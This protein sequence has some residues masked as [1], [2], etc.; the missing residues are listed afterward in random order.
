HGGEADA[1]AE[2]HDVLPL[3][4]DAEAFAERPDHVEHV[5]GLERGE[6]LGAAAD[7]L[8][9]ELEPAA[10]TRHAIDALRAAEPHLDR[11]RRRAQQLEELPWCG[12]ERSEEHTSELQSRVDLVCRLLLEKKKKKKKNIKEKKKKKFKKKQYK[13]KKFR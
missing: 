6:A 7:Y 11:V 10:R 4:R 9:E 2:H 12:R 1:A 8:V 5:A 13:L 3:R